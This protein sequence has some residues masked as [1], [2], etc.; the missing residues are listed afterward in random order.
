MQQITSS[1]S[2]LRPTQ[3]STMPIRFSNRGG[4]A[5]YIVN[6]VYPQQQPQQVYYQSPSQY[7]QV[8]SEG[9]RKN[10][11]LFLLVV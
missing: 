1:S 4:G 6:Q 5:G 10:W 2:Y 8:V 9:K 7:T 3:A 11:P